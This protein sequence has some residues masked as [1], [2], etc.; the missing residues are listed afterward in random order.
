MLKHVAHSLGYS[1]F[2]SASG[3]STYEVEVSCNRKSNSL[4]VLIM[5]EVSL[6]VLYGT[7]HAYEK[8]STGISA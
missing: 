1:L 7:V 2:G 8:A 3:V 5:S 4:R 6:T